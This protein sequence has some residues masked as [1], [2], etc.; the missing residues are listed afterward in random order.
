M[1]LRLNKPLPLF[2]DFRITIYYKPL[3]FI[4]MKK[5]KI[6]EKI[7]SIIEDFG[8]F[9]TGEIDDADHSPCVNSMGNL[10]ALA[11]GFDNDSAEIEVYDSAS[12]SCDSIKSYEEK[13]E[14]LSVAI[15]KEILELAEKYK[16]QQ[17]EE[18]K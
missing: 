1:G 11:E 12:Y 3:R 14:N 18:N 5:E 8:C 17:E 13:Y 15:L 2:Q 9:S 10:V 4:V 16:K 7:K 6:I